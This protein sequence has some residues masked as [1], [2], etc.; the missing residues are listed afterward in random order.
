MTA[1]TPVKFLP[2]EEIIRP[3]RPLF[4]F[5]RHM[6]GE[7]VDDLK[8]FGIEG[9]CLMPSWK[10]PDMIDFS[11][12]AENDFTDTESYLQDLEDIG[13]ELKKGGWMGKIYRFVPLDFSRDPEN[14]SSV[15][16]RT[17]AAGVKIHPLQNFPITRD[18]LE[19][20]MKVLEEH[21]AILY[22]HTD[23]VPSTEWKKTKNLMKETFGNI[24]GWFTGIPIILGHA[25]NNDSYVNIWK[26][27]KK[28]PHVYVETSLSPAPQEI[29]K[30]KR[31]GGVDRILF[32]S[33][34]PYSS[35]AVELQKIL[36]MNYFN[37]EEKAQVLRENAVALLEGRPHITI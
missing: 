36:K 34:H 26:W 35:T 33:N 8:R 16:Q 18:F 28:Y 31:H 10:T 11:A 37:E 19:P 2:V 14:L 27:V 21:D 1:I 25:G 7:I 24:A 32:G 12:P 3:F 6:G 5:H 22:V 13:S 4:D 15:I 30:I 20:Y 9:M 29:E 17:R 23:W